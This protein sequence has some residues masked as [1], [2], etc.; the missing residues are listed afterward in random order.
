MAGLALLACMVSGEAQAA[1]DCSLKEVTSIP[2]DFKHGDIRVDVSI[3]GETVKFILDTGTSFTE[4]GGALVRRMGLARS[5][6][7]VRMNSAK[8]TV[9]MD[10]IIV[11]DFK[12]GGMAAQSETLTEKDAWGDGTNGS[13]AGR[14]GVDFLRGF[15]IEIDPSQSVVNLFLPI[16]CVGHAAY[17]WNEHFELPL[18]VTQN[19]ALAAQVTLDGKPF[20]AYI[21]TGSSVSSVDIAEAKRLLGVPDSIEAPP[22]ARVDSDAPTQP[23]PTYTFNELAF[24]P[25]TLRHPKLELMRYRALANTTSSHI[26]QTYSSETPVVIGMD[27]LGK[28]HS[29]ISYANDM[30]Y[31]TLPN[32]RNPVP[33]K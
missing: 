1:A 11:P 6:N 14:L 20:R 22:P 7:T 9:E 28:F 10:R 4:I 32:E 27:V 24:G 23:N 15:D 5:N 13:V 31:F 17:W 30:M 3:G 29:M 12:L 16:T 21:A 18:S 33:A 8:G 19:Q 26:T 25:V 2:A